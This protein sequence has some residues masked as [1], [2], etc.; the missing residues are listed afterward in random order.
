M[1]SFEIDCFFVSPFL[2]KNL[3]AGWMAKDFPLLSIFGN[4]LNYV[5]VFLDFSCVKSHWISFYTLPLSL[6]SQ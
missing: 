1:D 3:N 6:L 2:P 5:E 4:V